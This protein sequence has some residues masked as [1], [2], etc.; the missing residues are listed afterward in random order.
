VLL[1]RAQTHHYLFVT[2]WAARDFDELWQT[3]PEAVK[4]LGALWRD[5]GLIDEAGKS[6]P[7]YATWKG[8]LSRPRE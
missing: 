1:S 3:F 4:D 2:C 5:T 6:R 8:W 7:A